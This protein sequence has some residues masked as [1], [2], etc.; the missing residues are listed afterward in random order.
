[1]ADITPE[2]VA[3]AALEWAADEVDEWAEQD[4][5]V[6]MLEAS[7]VFVIGKAMDYVRALASDPAT[8]AAIIAKAGEQK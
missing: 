7:D 5:K 6:R 8:L 4:F 3:R 2:A 1:M